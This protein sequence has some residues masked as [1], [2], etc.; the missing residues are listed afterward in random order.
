MT[1][2]YDVTV[3]LKSNENIKRVIVLYHFY[4]IYRS[5]KIHVKNV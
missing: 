5:N 3:R 4:G 2:Y 1:R